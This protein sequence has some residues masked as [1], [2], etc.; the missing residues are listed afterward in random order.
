MD[1]TLFI[2]VILGTAREGRE[3][4]AVADFVYSEIQKYDGIET[5][6][7]D[8][9]EYLQD[10]MTIPAWDN[11]PKTKEWRDIAAKADG[12][13]FIIPEYNHGYPGEFK[14]LLDQGYEEYFHKPVAVCGVSAGT[15]GG[16]R[17]LDH[18]QGV[19]N[20]LNMV[21]TSVIGFSKVEGL[22]GDKGEVQDKKYIEKV[23]KM[24][25][26]LKVY[27]KALRGVREELSA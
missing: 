17:V 21:N 2:P 1:A 18:L 10:P 6:F 5:Q 3:S 13:V 9:K 12:Y 16:A 25:H 27:G 22:F 4:K 23:E 15:L 8:V 11:N 14:L 7:I 20:E 19:W 24:A 26:L